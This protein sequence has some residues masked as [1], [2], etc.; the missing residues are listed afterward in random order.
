MRSGV[1]YKFKVTHRVLIGTIEKKK[2]TRSY[3][4]F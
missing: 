4:G 1:T 2:R 3:I